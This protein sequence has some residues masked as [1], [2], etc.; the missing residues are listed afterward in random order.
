MDDTIGIGRETFRTGRALVISADL[1]TQALA[2]AGGKGGRRH[3]ERFRRPD[4]RLIFDCKRT[5]GSRQSETNCK[6]GREEEGLSHDHSP[7]GAESE[8]SAN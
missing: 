4:R 6:S 2:F 8:T 5:M 1:S 3:L 7:V